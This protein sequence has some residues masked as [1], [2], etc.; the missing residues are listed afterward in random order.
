MTDCKYK[1]QGG[2]FIKQ[3][4]KQESLLSDE[5]VNRVNIYKRQFQDE[6][7]FKPNKIGIKNILA[8]SNQMK[9]SSSKKVREISD[10]LWNCSPGAETKTGKVLQDGIHSHV[11]PG[12]LF[13][14]RVS[15]GM[16]T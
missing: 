8:I 9:T 5:I 6:L 15:F 14:T 12:F 13:S 2:V 4:D 3:T 16:V 7:Y 1:R 11:E 10:Y